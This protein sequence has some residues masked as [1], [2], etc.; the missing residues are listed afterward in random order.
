MVPSH[1]RKRTNPNTRIAPLSYI[2]PE[3]NAQGAVSTTNSLCKSART[4][5]ANR[6]LLPADAEETFRT[7]RWGW[8]WL[9]ILEL[10][11]DDR[12][13]Y[14]KDGAPNVSGMSMW[15]PTS[16]PRHKWG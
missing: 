9:A 10:F 16:N 15:S 5:C 11:P 8:L 1:A 6:P 12:Y 7:N 3:K 13:L 14:V 2:R 4:L